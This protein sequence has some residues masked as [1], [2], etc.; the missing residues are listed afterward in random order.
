MEL[1]KRQRTYYGRLEQEKTYAKTYYAENKEALDK[2]AIDYYYKN[3]EAISLRRKQ[4]RQLR[5]ARLE[6]LNV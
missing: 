3:K 5:K 4:A 6:A 1:T 2:H